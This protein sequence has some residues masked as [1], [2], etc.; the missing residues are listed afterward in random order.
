MAAMN[1]ART[2][3][4]FRALRAGL[5]GTVG[6]VP[7]MGA[8]HEGHRSLMRRAAAECD[9][10]VAS[11][12]VNPT[13]FGPTDDYAQ[14]PRHEEADLAACE[15]EGVALVLMPSVEDVYPDG[16]STM[17][18]VGELS[19]ILEGA[20]RPGHFDGVATVVAK[21][22][23][24]AQPHR[25]YFGEKDAQQLLVIRRM[26]RDLLFPVEI[27][28]CP[29]IREEAGLALSSRNVYLSEEERRQALSLSRGLRAAEAAWR[30]G[31]R[32]ASALRTLVRDDI[33][34]QPLAQIDYVSLADIT[35]LQECEGVVVRTALLSLAVRF[36]RARLIDNTVLHAD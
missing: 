22:L 6:L 26:A 15:D 19:T 3:E 7:T 5:P 35:T 23:N 25:A 30:S 17:V 31:V 18:S 8:L 4:E 13:Q 27:V 9:S 29:I 28:G 2:V 21:L 10:V 36:G 16:A 34:A 33:A 20:A 11:I 24:I 14:Y 32:D 12:F 1:V